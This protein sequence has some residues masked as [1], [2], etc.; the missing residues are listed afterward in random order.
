M[1]LEYKYLP[2]IVVPTLRVFILYKNQVKFS[3]I[4]LLLLD[5]NNFVLTITIIDHFYK[6]VCMLSIITN[7]NLLEMPMIFKLFAKLH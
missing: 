3:R 5:I 7:F 6:L 2:L 1:L 4:S